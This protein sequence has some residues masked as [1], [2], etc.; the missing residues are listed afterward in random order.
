MG[1]NGVVLRLL[2]M[3]PGES[4]HDVNGSQSK[5]Y[6]LPCTDR[7]Y[8]TVYNYMIHSIA[9]HRDPAAGGVFTSY[10]I[11]K[12][13]RILNKKL[14]SKYCRRKNEIIEE[15]LSEEGNS[16]GKDDLDEKQLK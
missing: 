1:H 14:W 16:S 15:I 8:G 9:S 11:L 13:Q 4:L 5:L 12:I 3:L 2:H 7:D 6:T 10:Q